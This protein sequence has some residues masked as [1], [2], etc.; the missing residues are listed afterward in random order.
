[1]YIRIRI[2]I[3]IY[4]TFGLLCMYT[5]SASPDP[6]ASSRA[7]L[8]CLTRSYVYACIHRR[9]TKGTRAHTRREL[10]REWLWEP[11]ES[12]RVYIWMLGG[13]R[14]R[15]PSGQLMRRP[16]AP[17]VPLGPPLLP[18]G[19]GMPIIVLIMIEY[20]YLFGITRRER[21]QK[22]HMYGCARV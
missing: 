12:S 5:Y 14:R 20:A 6:S 16:A 10:I 21:I 8:F 4:S 1:M 9:F 18:W 11:K 13:G 17:R 3:N 19:N 2:P 15:D 7:M 22:S